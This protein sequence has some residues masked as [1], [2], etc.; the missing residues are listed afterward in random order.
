MPARC[1]SPLFRVVQH[2]SDYCRKIVAHERFLNEIYS[3]VQKAPM[4]YHVGGIARHINALEVR[5]DGAKLFCQFSAVHLRHHH[6]RYQQVK[7]SG[8]P[9]DKV[10]GSQIPPVKPE[11]WKTMDRSKRL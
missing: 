5:P 7:I 10:D 6:V 11:A 8:M 2:L 3:F 4:G 9:L 1:F